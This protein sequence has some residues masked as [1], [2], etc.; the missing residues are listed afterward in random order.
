LGSSG[1]ITGAFS[2]D[3]TLPTP[4][5]INKGGTGQTTAQAAIDALTAVSGAST[6]QV[7]TKDGSGNAVF[8]AA[9][10]GWVGTATSNLDM[11]T[12]NI[13][14]IDFLQLSAPTELTISTGAVTFSQSYHSVD[15]EAD[16]SSDNL[17]YFNGLT[18]GQ[19]LVL[20]SVDNSRDVVLRSGA[21]G[22]AKM[23][24][25]NDYTL[26]DIDYRW[27]G[28]ADTSVSN[29]VINELSRSSNTA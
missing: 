29:F 20:K 15:T 18:M 9:S 26:A 2:S 28:L 4:V 12:Y 21:T 19:F 5:P 7:L 6:N 16:A 11:D 17:D 22:D 27:T 23:N 10:A 13:F 3:T 8:A 25:V 24:G 1:L 14:D